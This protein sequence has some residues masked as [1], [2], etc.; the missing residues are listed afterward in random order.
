MVGVCEPLIQLFTTSTEVIQL[1]EVRA[2]VPPPTEEKD[3]ASD[4]G[5]VGGS[6]EKKE[7]DVPTVLV[8]QEKK[9][10]TTGQRIVSIRPAMYERVE[11]WSC[12]S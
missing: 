7:V 5:D 3:G 9:T 1:Q 4:G 11:S 10:A 8:L 2:D 12:P 6:T